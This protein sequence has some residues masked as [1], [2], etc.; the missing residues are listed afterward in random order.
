M[1]AITHAATALLLKQRFRQAGLWPL[2]IG[3][4][5]IELLWVVFV[6]TGIEHVRY[7][8]DAVHLD[9]LPYS[10]SITTTLAVALLAWG[11]VRYRRGEPTVAMAVALAVIESFRP[12]PNFSLQEVQQDES[13]LVL[14]EFSVIDCIAH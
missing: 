3:T 1:Y 5:A 7:T 12:P 11:F 9:F 10:H 4:Q 2:L 6:Y 13:M 14:A 8:R